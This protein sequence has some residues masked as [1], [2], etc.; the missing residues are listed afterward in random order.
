M[1]KAQRDIR[2]KK[3]VLEHAAR[4]G[5]VRKTCRYFGV[6]RSGFYRWKKAYETDGDEGLIN[7]KPCPYN[8]RLRTPPDIVEKVLHLRRTY[9]LGSIRI[10]WYLERY[11]GITM[12][13]AT[14]YRICRRHGLNRLPSRVGR[15]SVKT[16]RYEKQVPGAPRAGRCH[17]PEARRER[18]E[19]HA[20][21]SVHGHRR[22]HA[23]PGPHGLT[24]DIRRRT[25]STSS[26]TS[27][28][29]FRFGFTRCEPTGAM[30]FQAQF[31]WHLADRGICHVYITPRTP[32]LNGKVERS[33][34]TDKQ[35]FYQ[36]LT[37]TGD[38]DLNAKLNEWENFYNY[39]R[40]HGAFHGKTPYEALRDKLA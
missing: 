10:V 5:N 33:H 21:V 36:L 24:R 2:R 11:H 8:P 14:V 26:I 22:C 19:G 6:A 15:R 39:H 34:R 32:R 35:E 18:R 12:C 3:R 1:N 30:S 27:S 4:I 31:H 25:P 23:H 9:H 16:H 17:V 38:V 13:D 28:R 37:Y 20:A 29:D 7:K 40:P